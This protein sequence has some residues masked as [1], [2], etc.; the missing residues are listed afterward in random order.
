MVES[1]AFIKMA[2]C[3]IMLHASFSCCMHGKY[4]MQHASTGY[5]V[6]SAQIMSY[7][8]RRI[9]E[10]MT[11]WMSTEQCHLHAVVV[12]WCTAAAP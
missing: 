6:A 3:V 8:P 9:A 11:L 2:M 4:H 10:L 7:T 1:V 12:R 5:S